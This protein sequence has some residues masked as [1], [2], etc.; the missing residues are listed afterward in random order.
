MC[1]KKNMANDEPSLP[2]L[3]RTA[4]GPFKEFLGQIHV[5]AADVQHVH[6]EVKK[7][8]PDEVHALMKGACGDLLQLLR[9][10]MYPEQ[11]KHKQLKQLLPLPSI[12]QQAVPSTEQHWVVPFEEYAGHVRALYHA[13]T[14]AFSQLWKF[15]LFRKKQ[16]LPVRA[17]K[18]F[19]PVAPNADPPGGTDM[20]NAWYGLINILQR[21]KNMHVA[22]TTEASKLAAHMRKHGASPDH[23]KAVDAWLASTRAL[24]EE[25]ES[26]FQSA[27][28]GCTCG[29]AEGS[30]QYIAPACVVKVVPKPLCKPPCAALTAADL[31]AVCPT[32]LKAAK[33]EW[34]AEVSGGARRRAKVQ[35]SGARKRTARQ[36]RRK[37]SNT[38]LV[39]GSRPRRTKGASKKP[40]RTTRRTT[41][42]RRRMR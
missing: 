37:S 23:V 9:P 24:T 2:L 36:G 19:E 28:E 40:V 3:W 32:V 35:A 10:L 18:L 34:K 31:R 6:D 21:H 30:L 17:A 41:H 42:M 5:N 38:R 26:T 29:D 15:N 12:L 39:G 4:M 27:V 25:A 13:G 16:W 8:Y 7:V 1:V 33:A 20:H 14:R 11:L 22:M